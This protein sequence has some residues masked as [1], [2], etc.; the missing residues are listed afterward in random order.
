M[1]PLPLHQPAPLRAN[2]LLALAYGLAGWLALQTAIPPGYV[3]PL[4]P[5][6][7]IALAALLIGGRRLLPGVFAGAIG[8]QLLA[9]QQSGLAYP[10]P[11]I[12]LLPALGATLQA[13]VGH[14]LAR[15]LIGRA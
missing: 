7:G 12:L 14:W 13:A 1:N 4:F 11:L 9:A 2:L 10:G 8:V 6:A 5:P 3:A 15:R